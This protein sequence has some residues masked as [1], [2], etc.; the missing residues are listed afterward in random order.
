MVAD[1]ADDLRDV[2][3]LSR[4]HIYSTND[5][6]GPD[7]PKWRAIQKAVRVWLRKPV[8]MDAKEPDQPWNVRL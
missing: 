7:V 8:R 5:G 6:H 4:L 2:P 3:I 1:A